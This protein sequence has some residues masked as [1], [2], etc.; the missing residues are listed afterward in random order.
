MATEHNFTP[1]SSD[2]STVVGGS[3]ANRRIMC[4]GS[5]QLERKLPPET[6][7]EE[8]SYAAEGTALHEAIAYILDNDLALEQ[9]DQLVGMEFY[10]HVLD[11]KLVSEALVP[12]VEFFDKL[13]DISNKEGGLDFELEQK[14]HFP[15]V[16]DAHGTSDLVGRTKKRSIILDWKFG[17]GKPVY[18]WK[19]VPEGTSDARKI[20]LPFSEQESWV[21]GNPQLMFYGRSAMFTLPDMFEQ[22]DDWPVELF[23]VQPR[24]SD[25]LGGAKV[26]RHSTTVG[27][28]KAFGE[29]L[30]ERVDLAL[31][32]G[33]PLAK[34][35][36][37]HCNWCPAQTICPLWTGPVLDLTR[38]YEASEL[39]ITRT[40]KMPVEEYAELLGHYMDL[41]DAIAELQS[42]AQLATVNL[43]EQG[44]DVPGWCLK[45]KRPGHDAWQDDDKAEAYLGRQGVPLK[46]RRIMKVMTPAAARKALKALGKELK[47]S[48]VKPGVSSGYTLGRTETTKDPIKL[49]SAAE[50]ANKLAAITGQ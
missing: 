46:E 3:T 25:D 4:P 9:L 43:L 44:I 48:Y 39:E 26:S 30:K 34:R 29:M 41:F 15:L 31:T 12:A 18:A 40:D 14:C 5:Y 28:L 35:K 38:A 11:R 20:T 37:D 36:G 16:D 47:E 10:G 6:K 7:N 27:E 19:E 13:V 1:D 49:R 24:I 17:A 45:A 33:A 2:H 50:I 32:A 22:G 42:E 23:I 8:S 21:V